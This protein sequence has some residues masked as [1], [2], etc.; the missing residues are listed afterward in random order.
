MSDILVNYLTIIKD[1]P[2]DVLLTVVTK[3]H[4]AEDIIPLLEY[5]HKYYGENYVQEAQEKWMDILPKYN[6]NLKLIGRLQSNKIKDALKIFDEIHSVYSLE[7]AHKIS[8]NLQ[9]NSRTKIFYLQVNVG[10]EVQK[11][12]INP[13]DVIDFFQKTPLKISGLMCIPPVGEPSKYFMKMKDLQKEIKAKFG[14]D[15]KLSMGMSPDFME[16]IKCGSNEVR[17]G[18]AIFGARTSLK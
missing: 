10:N 11:S 7:I 15:I 13:E 2:K 17:V 14:L 6:V 12:G 1:I 18:S 16:A 3:Q 5:G 8:S 4:D 9:S